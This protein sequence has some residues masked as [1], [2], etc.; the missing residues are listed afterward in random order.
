MLI[1]FIFVVVV[2]LCVFTFL[3]PCSD[4]RYDFRIKKCA[5]RLYLQL[6]VGGFMSYLRYLCLFAYS[7]VQHILCFVFALFFFDLCA[8]CCQ[9]LWTIHSWLPL[10]FSLTSTVIMELIPKARRCLCVYY[11]NNTE[12]YGKYIQTAYDFLRN[13]FTHTFK[14]TDVPIILGS[15][16]ILILHVCADSK[17]TMVADMVVLSVKLN[18][19]GKALG[20]Q[21][22][23]YFQSL[24]FCSVL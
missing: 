14:S 1:F 17:T 6:F 2:L 22:G 11:N 10:Q 24:V 16:F 19:L 13:H 15:C 21:W 8:L 5:V 12:L 3:V 4:V 18:H 23:V 9:F 20:F 7:G